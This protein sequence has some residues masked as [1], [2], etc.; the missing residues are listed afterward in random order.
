MLVVAGWVLVKPEVRDEA[1][2][3]MTAMATASRDEAGCISYRFFSDIEHP[4]RF[5]AFEEWGS[6]E[7]LEI[8]FQTD[9]MKE[10]QRALGRVIA[11]RVTVKRYEVES[12][13]DL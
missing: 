2:R 6:K 13:S 3:A 4:D 12:I 11:E 7:A 1:I 5:F 9:H 8:H 10:F